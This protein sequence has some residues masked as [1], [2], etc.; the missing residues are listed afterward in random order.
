YL[1]SREDLNYIIGEM[2]AELN[3]GHSYV[4]GGDQPRPSSIKGG[5]LGCDFEVDHSNGLY[6][7]SKIYK[8]RNWD[9]KFRAPL[10]QPGIGVKEGDYL[11][12][13]NGIELMYP[14][15]PYAL[16]ETLVDKQTVIKVSPDPK[17]EDAK[18]YTVIPVANDLNLRYSDW[19]ESNRQKVLEATDGRVG[20]L[21]VPNTAVGGL[22]EFGKY[23]YGQTTMDGIIID[24]RYN[25]GG[26]MPSLF[27]DRLARKITSMWAKR[28]GRVTQFPVRAPKGHLACVINAYAGSGGDAF[29]YMFRQAGLGPLIGK[30]TW[31]GLI[32]MDRNLPLMDGGYC[33]VPTIGFFDLDGEWA[34]ENI[35]VHPDIEV[36]NRPDLVV[37]GHD[38]Q[39]EKAIEYLKKKIKEEPPKLPKKPKNPDKS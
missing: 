12:E 28:Y 37:E 31:G 2:I 38:P 9:P 20:Y 8:G 35:G 27:I 13:I 29:P 25:S 10:A 24:V 33:T 18:E 30:R 6:R 3:I 1:A 14:D 4:G 26:W 36:D 7:I 15:N 16:L 21:H 32:G 17:S 5:K 34:V 23:F 39:L 19:V 22:I 11:L